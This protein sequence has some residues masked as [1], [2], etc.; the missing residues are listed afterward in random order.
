MKIMLTTFLLILLSLLNVD[1][2]KYLPFDTLVEAQ[3][4]SEELATASHCVNVATKTSGYASVITSPHIG[5]V[6]LPITT[7]YNHQSGSAVNVETLLTA[8][9]QAALI[10]DASAYFQECSK[11]VFE[12]SPTKLFGLSAW[13]K[14]GVGLTAVSGKASQWD[15]QSGNA[16]H[17]TQATANFRPTINTTDAAFNN[18]TSLSFDGSNDVLLAN[19][20][21]GFLDGIDHAYTVVTVMQKD[22]SGGEHMLSFGI[23]DLVGNGQWC[24]GIRHYSRNIYLQDKRDEDGL[25]EKSFECG[26]TDENVDIVRWQSNGQSA[27]TFVN[28]V[29]VGTGDLNCVKGITGAYCTI[30]GYPNFVDINAAPYNP[31]KGKFAELIVYNRLLTAGEQTQIEDYCRERFATY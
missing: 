6:L 10:D 23:S 1:A 31:M 9:E 12:F 3:A 2:A 11:P 4:R 16:R 20:L 17:A 5:K 27:E 21:A 29:S 14:A 19:S 22:N 25:D 24:I 28:G 30:G 15:D 8:P 18:L 26:V 7:V 13:F